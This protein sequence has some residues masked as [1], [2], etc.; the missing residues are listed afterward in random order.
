MNATVLFQTQVPHCGAE[1]DNR[2]LVFDE[3]LVG[4]PAE[5]KICPF[6]FNLLLLAIDDF[7]HLLVLDMNLDEA[8]T[9][10]RFRVPKL[11]GPSFDNIESGRHIGS[12]T[13]NQAIFGGRVTAGSRFTFLGYDSRYLD[14]KGRFQAHFGVDNPFLLGRHDDDASLLY[15]RLYQFIGENCE[16]KKKK[17]LLH[18]L[19]NV[20]EG[21]PVSQ[22][23]IDKE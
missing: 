3:R 12:R 20:V 16:K 7:L 21:R 1:L 17:P 2:G 4:V 22:I 6:L 19:D 9:S 8:A 11:F 10:D 5:F 13:Y 18:C 15:Q 14:R 23:N